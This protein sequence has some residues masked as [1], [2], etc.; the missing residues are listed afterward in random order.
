VRE[1]LCPPEQPP[2]EESPTICGIS[3]YPA[4]R[5]QFCPCR[6]QNLPL[7]PQGRRLAV[8][9]GRRWRVVCPSTVYGSVSGTR[10]GRPEKGL[11][12]HR[13]RALG[14]MSSKGPSVD[15]SGDASDR[16]LL[17]SGPT[18]SS[19]GCCGEL[20]RRMSFIS[21][22]SRSSRR[23]CVREVL[24]PGDRSAQG[25]RET[26]LRFNSRTACRPQIGVPSSTA[27]GGF[28]QVCPQTGLDLRA[29]TGRPRAA[30]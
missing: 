14:S 7:S 30:V 1:V 26:F 3:R 2:Q 27:G 17:D 25:I 15:R 12:G 4:C 20:P 28:P 29:R 6:P 24:C 8:D 5:P 21:E 22:L 23:K 18:P 13:R 9:E 11:P 16:R 19:P 10:P